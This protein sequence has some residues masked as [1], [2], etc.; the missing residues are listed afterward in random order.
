MTRGQFIEELKLLIKKLPEQERNE[1]IYDYEEHFE[2][3]LAEGRSEAEIVKEL[4]SPK[5][6]A[7]EV[8]A[9]YH[10][11]QAEVKKS[12]PNIMRAII[13][14]ISLSFFNLIFLLGPIVGIIGVYAA[15]CVTSVA[16]IFSSI[17]AILSIFMGFSNVLLK[18]FMAMASGGFGVLLGISMIY[19][20]KFL[21]KAILKYIKA[22]VRIVKGEQA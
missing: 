2:M 4:G 11:S 18:L 8:L 22:N 17:A 6:I 3:G 19:A 21:Y 1:I 5:M 14:A 16:F 15:L 13:A 7:K 12:V 9:S 10:I 20:G